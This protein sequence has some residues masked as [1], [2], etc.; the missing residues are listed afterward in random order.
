MLGENSKLRGTY[1]FDPSR[2]GVDFDLFWRGVGD[3]E[4]Y[5]IARDD[6]AAVYSV[7]GSKIGRAHV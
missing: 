5:L 4:S 1:F 3:S 2:E 7:F 6:P